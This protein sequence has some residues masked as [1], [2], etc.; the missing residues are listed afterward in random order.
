[1]IAIATLAAL[2]LG[3]PLVV[4]GVEC[5]L[6]L[7]PL[8]RH[9]LHG[10][11][12]PRLAVIIPAHNE[13]DCIADTV[14]CIRAQLNDAAEVIVIAD[15]C[16]DATADNARFA[17]ATAW[18]RTDAARVGKGYALNF[19]WERL[20]RE[21]LD[22][23]VYV[24]ADC[25]PG[26]Q[27]IPT[28]ARLAHQYQKPVQAAYTMEAPR[29]SSTLAS[30]SALA[31][32]VKNVVRPRGL[33]RLGFPCL[34]TGSG[35][36]IPIGALTAV[37]F[38]DGHI[39]E[40]ARISSDLTIAG[41]AALPCMEVGI[42]SALPDGRSGFMTQRTRW[43]HGHLATILAEA[44]RLMWAAVRTR[45]WQPLALCLELAVPP[46]SLLAWI[47]A[48]LV[49][50]LVLCCQAMDSWL[51]L[52]GYL[53]TVAFGL[54]GL[55][56]A[57]LVSARA[58][59]PLRKAVRIPTYII[60]KAPMYLRFIHRRQRNWVRTERIQTKTGSNQGDIPVR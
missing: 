32:Y 50:T 1:M 20:R 34:L 15:N 6:S 10:S 39:A 8:R 2:G 41:F 27:C 36:A 43:E 23:V 14:K 33:Q 49:I 30:V 35:M 13:A 53:A 29:R 58:I 4:L 28:I 59:L 22:V 56:A 52:L 19:A 37:P 18:E 7:L 9:E 55:I 40:D 21:S 5:W 24:D 25:Y 16:S 54:S 51:P 3:L 57:W 38:P 26:P 17:G 46:L 44:P 42:T 47:V 12:Q 31:V 45:A 60:V 48:A 11:S